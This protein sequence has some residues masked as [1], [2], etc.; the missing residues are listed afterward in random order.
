MA[1]PVHP[2][3]NSIQPRN[4]LGFFP[5]SPAVVPPGTAALA[6]SDSTRATLSST[7]VT[8]RGQSCGDDVRVAGRCC[9]GRRDQHRSDCQRAADGRRPIDYVISGKYY[10]AGVSAASVSG[11]FG[12][13]GSGKSTVTIKVAK[14]VEAGYHPLVLTT[15]AGQGAA[16]V[17][18]VGRCREVGWAVVERSVVFSSRASL[19]PEPRCISSGLRNQRCR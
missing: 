5:A 16:N 6:R 9:G 10:E 11:K 12:D 2:T 15:K 17:H 18:A 7:P 4:G 13:D 3:T 1:A 19:L 8:Y 14:S